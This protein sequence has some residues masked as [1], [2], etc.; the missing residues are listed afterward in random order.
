VAYGDKGSYKDLEER[1]EELLT[2][3]SAFS[4]RNQRI[5]FSQGSVSHHHNGP[6][7]G[8]Y[9]ERVPFVRRGANRNVDRFHDEAKRFFWRATGFSALRGTGLMTNQQINTYG[10]A[11]WEK[12]AAR[13]GTPIND[14]DRINL[15]RPNFQKKLEK[16]LKTLKAVKS[17]N[18]GHDAA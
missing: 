3:L 12:F 10:I 16:H 11:T 6:I 13:F 14:E 15:D 17:K 2:A 8:R 5:G 1:A 9:R 18:A 7:Y 4:L